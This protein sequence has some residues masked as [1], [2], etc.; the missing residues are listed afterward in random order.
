MF[1]ILTP[2]YWIIFPDLYLNLIQI[3]YFLK[4]GLYFLQ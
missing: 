4:S 1:P 3:S 2:I